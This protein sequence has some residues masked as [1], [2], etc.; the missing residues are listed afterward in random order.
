MKS[1]RA[2]GLSLLVVAH[3]YRAVTGM[4]IIMALKCSRL[5]KFAAVLLR[6][7]AYV[8]GYI[9]IL[10]DR[11]I[12]GQFLAVVGGLSKGSRERLHIVTLRKWDGWGLMREPLLKVGLAA[13]MLVLTSSWGCGLHLCGCQPCFP[14]LSPSV[15]SHATPL[16]PAQVPRPH[17]W[18]CSLTM[19]IVSLSFT[20]ATCLFL[21]QNP[22]TYEMGILDSSSKVKIVNETSLTH[23]LHLQL[24]V[25]ILTKCPYFALSHPPFLFAEQPTNHLRFQCS[26]LPWA[27]GTYSEAPAQA[28]SACL[29]SGVP[30][31]R[32]RCVWRFWAVAFFRNS[33]GKDFSWL[34]PLLPFYS[35]SL[36]LLYA[37][38]VEDHSEG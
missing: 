16:A 31:S 26:S 13:V 9:L 34:W 2:L 27:L 18:P 10:W 35:L 19:G 5:G 38:T 3:G 4:V 28:A 24:S 20:L 32:C 25:E 17:S 22:R 21:E 15:M 33:V 8:L 11:V 37:F 14:S 30:A 6:M 1:S 29:P 36:H 23:D 12:W 7:D